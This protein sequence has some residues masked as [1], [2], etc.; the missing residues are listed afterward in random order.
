MIFLTPYHTTACHGHVLSTVVDAIIKSAVSD[1]SLDNNI[2]KAKDV[3]C[4]TD[5]GAS[6]QA[7]AFGQPI[8]FDKLET[9]KY[10][11]YFGESNS[12]DS[13]FFT[14]IDA[15]PFGRY[16]TAAAK[17][18]IKN[19]VEFNLAMLKAAT[20]EYWINGG[21]SSMQNFSPLPMIIFASWISENVARR[22]N[23]DVREQASLATYAAYYYLSL[24][25]NDEV[26]KEQE[27]SRYAMIIS[28][29]LRL[30]ASEVLNL[31]E[32]TE[33]PQNI[34][35]FCT[36][37]ELAVG[38]VRLKDFNKLVLFSLIGG[39]WFGTNARETVCVALEHPPTWISLLTAAYSERGF[40]K[41][42]ISQL[43]ERN[44]NRELG[45]NFSRQV[46]NLV[47]FEV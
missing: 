14:V 11:P 4:L 9:S 38:T 25:T 5:T 46:F 19:R 13:R 7:P 8:M 42:G 29:G 12:H 41:S 20:T 39:T 32:T 17:F 1:N 24:F 47:Q 10:T 26:I 40:T 2:V 44:S 33:P 30:N 37:A 21:V 28:K 15:R 35:D 18:D 23:L 34:S 6:Q 45:K 36:R 27:R 43:T 16:N 22:F 31:L 3:W